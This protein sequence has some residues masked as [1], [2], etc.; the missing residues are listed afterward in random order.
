MTVIQ[1]YNHERANNKSCSQM[2]DIVKQSPLTDLAVIDIPLI[3]S[4]DEFEP[5][6]PIGSK[7]KIHKVTGIYYTIAN[8]SPKFRSKMKSIL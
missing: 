5:S 4:L 8:I 2:C 7:R 6:N 1:L 3:L